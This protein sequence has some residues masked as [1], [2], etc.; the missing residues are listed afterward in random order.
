[1]K[2]TKEIRTKVE[3]YIL[4]CI[5]PEGYGVVCNS[6]KEKLN[7]LYSTFINE[8]GYPQ[9]FKRYGN[10][11]NVFVE[12]LKGLPS[13]FRVHF[14]NYDILEQL[15]E[16]GIIK[17][18]VRNEQYYL[19]I[20][21]KKIYMV[22]QAMLRRANAVPKPKKERLTVDEFEVQG[23][24][25]NRWECVTTEET[26]KEAIVRIKEYQANEKGTNFRIKRK[27]VYKSL[28]AELKRKLHLDE[29]NFSSHETDLYV[30]ALPK[31]REYLK[32][33]YQFW[34][35][36]TFFTSQI[37]NELWFDVPFAHVKT[38]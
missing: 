23:L 20:W 15:R 11:Q 32:A 19:E 7:F 26:R 34:G 2:A 36:V 10:E 31:V 12:W 16:W 18:E 3:A 9:N 28:K 38:K 14:T 24:Y 4:D 1:M 35:N 33:N 30:R 5:T 8:Y 37:D 25:L 21:W 22:F 6:D 29:S 13:V 17:G 27:L